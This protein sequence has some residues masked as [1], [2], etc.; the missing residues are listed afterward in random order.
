M[1]TR[2]SRWLVILGSPHLTVGV[3]ILLIAGS[4]VAG[5]GYTTPFLALFFPAVLFAVNMIAAS[6]NHKGL[7][8]KPALLVF[9]WSLM[10]LLLLA[11]LGRSFYLEGWVR[12]TEGVMF[13]GILGG[14]ESGPWHNSQLDKISFSYEGF[15]QQIAPTGRIHVASVHMN[16]IDEQGGTHST[17]LASGASLVLHGYRISLTRNWGF[18]PIFLWIP[19]H[20]EQTIGGVQL[21][22]YPL[23]S[24]NQSLS[25]KIPNTNK[26]IWIMLE[27]QESFLDPD[28][29][30]AYSPRSHHEVPIVLR[31]DHRRWLLRPGDVVNFQEGRLIYQETRS[32]MGFRISRDDVTSWMLAAV[33]TALASLAFHYKKSLGSTKPLFV[34]PNE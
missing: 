22:G 11:V 5:K 20:G 33:M 21:P 14:M 1:T 10:A 9:H 34:L 24:F 13:D 8:S 32:W 26:E 4:H 2:E 30:D 7:S 16:W 29:P 17:I 6:L 31:D 28:H 15:Q 18:T 27:H 25:W 23:D 12:L 19:H 3:I